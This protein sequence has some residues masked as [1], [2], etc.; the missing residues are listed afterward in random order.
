[1]IHYQRKPTELLF[2]KLYPISMMKQAILS[3]QTFECGW[4]KKS[5]VHLPRRIALT[6][7]CTFTNIWKLL[8]N[9]NRLYGIM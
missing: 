7:A 9:Q 2:L 3:K 6:V 5:N 8:S 4:S 1:M